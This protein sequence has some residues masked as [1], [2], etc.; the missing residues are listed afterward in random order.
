MLEIPVTFWICLSILI[1]LEGMKRRSIQLIFFFPL[2]AAILTKSVLGLLPVWVFLSAIVL[3]VIDWRKYA[4]LIVSTLTGIVLGLSWSIHEASVFGQHALRQH[5]LGEIATRSSRKLPWLKALFG[6]PLIL[7]TVFQPVILPAIVGVVR[8]F[9]SLRANRNPGQA[10]LL[11]WILFPLIFYNLSGTRSSRYIFP[12]LPPLALCAG[13]W[14]DGFSIRFTSIFRRWLAPAILFGIAVISWIQPARIWRDD[15][16][17][18]KS[19]SH[20]ITDRIA[21]EESIPY[22]GSKYWEIANPLLYYAD[23][24]LKPSNTSAVE[25]VDAAQKTGILV[26]DRS[27]LPEVLPLL[28]KA[29]VLLQAKGWIILRTGA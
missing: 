1:L 23:R 6:Y 12:I 10:V 16:R 8:I 21:E 22:L 2:A 3:G 5:Y 27:L 29:T 4:R 14:L 17:E 15:N 9:R 28:P 18:L 13:Y 26:V 20:L 19:Y 25:A 7:V 11:I 24:Q